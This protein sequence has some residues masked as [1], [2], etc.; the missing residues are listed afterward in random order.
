MKAASATQAHR[1]K[2]SKEM[3]APPSPNNN[4]Q[5]KA[6]MKSHESDG[7]SASGHGILKDVSRNGFEKVGM[8]GVAAFKI[9]LSF[10]FGACG[11]MNN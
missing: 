9:K 3:L 4:A 5:H 8:S 10:D 11:G 7:V 6:D 1:K 2:K